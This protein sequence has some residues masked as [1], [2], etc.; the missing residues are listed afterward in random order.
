MVCAY[1]I[2]LMAAEPS[3]CYRLLYENWYIIER[4]LY[5]QDPQDP[6]RRRP[7]LA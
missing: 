7:L 4:K 1:S 3:G 5:E 6:T 2:N